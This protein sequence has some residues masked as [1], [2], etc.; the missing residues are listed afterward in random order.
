M[1]SGRRSTRW[2]TEGVEIRMERP[3]V[4]AEE[5]GV[6]EEEVGVQFIRGL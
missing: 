5:G 1:R 3:E 6:E 2:T 4:E